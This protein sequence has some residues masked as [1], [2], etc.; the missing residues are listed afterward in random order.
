MLLSRTLECSI[1][2]AEALNRRVRDGNGCVVLAMVT[3]P[4]NGQKHRRVLPR[5]TRCKSEAWRRTLFLARS[6]DPPALSA[7]RI[8]RIWS[9][10][11]FASGLIL[12][13]TVPAACRIPAMGDDAC[14][15]AREKGGQASRLISTGQLKPS[16][17]LHLLPIDPVVFRVPS[18]LLAEKGDFI[19]RGAWHLDAFSAYPFAT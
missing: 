2:A 7:V 16:P 10:N 4:K 15:R 8:C 19:F 14:A 3:S 6:R 9:F 13:S 17:V 5:R 1:I 12:L 18:V 11:L